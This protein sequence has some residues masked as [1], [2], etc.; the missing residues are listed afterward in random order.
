[1]GKI[2]TFNNKIVTINNKWC[3]EYVEPTPPGPSGFVMNGSNATYT[4][5]NNHYTVSWQS[6]SY[7]NGYNGGGKQYILVNNNVTAPNNSLMYGSSP[8]SSAFAAI[9]FDAIKILGTSTGELTTNYGA[10]SG[11]G[12]YLTWDAPI[13]GTSLEQVQAY[14]ANVTITIVDP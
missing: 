11:I 6:P 3:E 9:D 14:F 4:L 2:Y 5:N 8:T 13:W 10:G 1:M 12:S 7:P